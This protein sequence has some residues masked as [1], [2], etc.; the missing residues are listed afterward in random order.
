MK[1]LKKIYKKL[2]QHFGRPIYPPAESRFEICVRIILTQRTTWQ[3]VMS[4]IQKLKQKKM[5]NVET[6]ASIDLQTLEYLLR[7]LGLSKRKA[8]CLKKFSEYCLEH[9]EGDLE[10]WFKKN[11][12]EIR[13]ELLQIPGIG[14][15]TAD[16]IL[17]AGA[18]KPVIPIDTYL[19]RILTRTGVIKKNMKNSEIKEIIKNEIGSKTE[20]LRTLRLLLIELAQK[21]CRN[22]PL[23]EKCPL[24]L[25]CKRYFNKG[26]PY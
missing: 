15:E 13:K 14:K 7:P 3:S 18:E 12:K 4:I 24:N 26:N 6:L 21:Y 1:H 2:L 17:L 9:Y 20:N 19:K 8:G 5:L 10:K 25:Y 22:R 16:A 11:E 23:C